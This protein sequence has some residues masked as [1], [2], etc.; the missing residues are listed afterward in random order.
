MLSILG[1]LFDSQIMSL[2][3]RPLPL[4]EHEENLTVTWLSVTSEIAM[5]QGGD[6]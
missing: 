3:L 5:T 2:S 1:G 4:P 6:T